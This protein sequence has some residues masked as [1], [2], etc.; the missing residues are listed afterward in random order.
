MIYVK[1]GSE[2]LFRL[3]EGMIHSILKFTAIIQKMNNYRPEKCK[4][5]FLEI[6]LPIIKTSILASKRNPENFRLTIYRP[7]LKTPYHRSVKYRTGNKM[8]TN[9]HG[10]TKFTV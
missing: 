3:Q 6:Q 1:V 2:M 8:L 4:N 7:V 5:R 9:T 10:I